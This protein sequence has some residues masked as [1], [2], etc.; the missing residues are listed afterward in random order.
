ME[1]EDF[2]ILNS[3]LVFIKKIFVVLM[4]KAFL[5]YFVLLLCFALFQNSTQIGEVKVANGVVIDRERVKVVEIT[6]EV[7]DLNAVNGTDQ[8]ITSKYEIK[9]LNL[10]FYCTSKDLYRYEACLVFVSNCF[11]QLHFNQAQL[12]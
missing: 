1:F 7:E 10:L 12:L 4:S 8:I 9:F 2:K 6:I 5:L 11:L 3:V